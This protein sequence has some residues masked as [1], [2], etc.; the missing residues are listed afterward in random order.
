MNK[1][2]T[3]RI[4]AKKHQTDVRAS[5]S[6]SIVIASDPTSVAPIVRAMLTVDTKKG[7]TVGPTYAARRP[8]VI[9]VFEEDGR[10]LARRSP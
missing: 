9:R 4:A 6:T 2:C 3:L 1:I 5:R 7:A 10:G 8:A